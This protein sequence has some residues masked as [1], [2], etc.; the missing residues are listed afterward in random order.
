MPSPSTVVDKRSIHS[1]SPDPYQIISW[2]DSL[3]RGKTHRC[4]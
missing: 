1:K 3:K 4:C 2:S